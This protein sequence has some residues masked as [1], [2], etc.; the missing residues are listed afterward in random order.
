MYTQAGSVS[1]QDENKDDE[2]DGEDDTNPLFQH[3]DAKGVI[4]WR[5]FSDFT[6][7]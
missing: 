4:G 7:R 2:D 5:L 3:A 1:Y 6:G